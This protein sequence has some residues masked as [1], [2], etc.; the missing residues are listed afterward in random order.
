M[1][2][3]ENVPFSLEKKC[4][5]RSLRAVKSFWI[6]EQSFISKKVGHQKWCWFFDFVC[7]SGCHFTKSGFSQKKSGI[8]FYSRFQLVT[9]RLYEKSILQA[10]TIFSSISGFL[11]LNNRQTKTFVCELMD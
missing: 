11:Q 5:F 6:K 7:F 2:H 8:F 9:S 10:T 1:F 3:K 4:N